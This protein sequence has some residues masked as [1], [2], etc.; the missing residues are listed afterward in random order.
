MFT[1]ALFSIAKLWK[2]ARYPHPINGL[3]ECSIYIQG[4]LFNH[5]EE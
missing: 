5:K 3:R 2:Q 4:I 1:A